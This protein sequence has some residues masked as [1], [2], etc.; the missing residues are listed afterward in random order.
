MH[1]RAAAWEAWYARCLVQSDGT[2]TRSTN[3]YNS[4]WAPKYKRQYATSQSRHTLCVLPSTYTT[5][6]DKMIPTLMY[7]KVIQEMAGVGTVTTMLAMMVMLEGT[8][9]RVRRSSL[10]K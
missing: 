10:L 5:A 1:K 9:A 7:T 3:A 2:P 4:Q 6:K 8:V